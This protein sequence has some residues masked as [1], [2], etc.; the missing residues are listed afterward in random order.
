MHQ[1]LL[2]WCQD[3][4]RLVR[5]S[6]PSSFLDLACLDARLMLSPYRTFLLLAEAPCIERVA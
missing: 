2:D 1:L 3:R 6:S 4:D 5:P